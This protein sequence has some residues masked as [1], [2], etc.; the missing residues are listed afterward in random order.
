MADW[1]PPS[2]PKG[3]VSRVPHLPGLDGLRAVAVVAV[4]VYHANNTWL[5]GGFLGVEVFFVISGY[6]ITLLLIAEHERSGRVD[7]KQFWLRR[8]RRLLPALFGML[9]LLVVYLAV[10]FRSAQGRTRGDIVA[11]VGYISNWYQIWVGAGY[12]ASEAFAPLRHLWSLA[13]EEQFY[14]LWPIIM[15][16]I[17]SRGRAQLP[18]VALW[19]FGV[20]VA[21]AA[22]T[23]VLYVPGDISSACT[24]EAMHGYWKIAGRCVSVNDALYLGTI[25]RAGGLMMGAAFAMV[26]RPMALMRGPM[27]NKSR[28]LDVLALFG[29]A[30]LGYLFWKLHLAD[31][32][33]DINGSRFDPWL[34]RGGIFATGAATLLVIAAATHQRSLAG[35]LLGNPLF[36]W[37][38]TR[39]YGLYLYHWPIYQIIRKEAGVTLSVTQF[40][41]AML[42]TVPLTEL[43][44]RY[45]EMPIR[46]GAIGNWLRRER[47]RPSRAVAA[48]RRQL[49]AGGLAFTVLLGWAGVSIAM[50][51]NRCVG[52]V[53]CSLVEGQESSADD[54]IPTQPSSTTESTETATT[55][56][57]DEGTQPTGEPGESTTTA[58]T[59]A[60]TT[61]EPPPPPKP[62]AIGESVMLGAQPQLEAGGFTVIAVK[63]AQGADIANTIGQLR[64]GGQIG[65]TIVIQSGTNGSVS[66][67]TYAQ[68]MSFLPPDSTPKVIFLTVRAPGKGWIDGNNENIYA[69]PGQYPNVTVLE[70]KS[71]VDNG[72]VPGMAGDGIHLGTNAAKQT[73]ANMIFDVIGR[74]DLQVPVE[75]DG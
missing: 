40:V 74:R 50:A 72:L 30:A 14:L 69:L 71:F 70:W 6:L 64:A 75:A 39:S 43:S 1:S 61:T 9:A 57:N 25:T 52:E 58:T 59:A 24:P 35:V 37:I 22:V 29:V 16:A 49:A 63:S 42:V 4:M 62:L 26:W 5:H 47:R 60:P 17:L 54:T 11:G 3:Q 23:A 32:A 48:R 15:V 44:Y 20:S 18:R 45:V 33:L 13:V 31:P 68:M 8:A 66:A 27:R 2:T 53:E 19:L 34:F 56:A 67:E 10:G 21:I 36:D 7:L 51:P 55:V 73:Y 28:Q 46:R 38:G 41:A 12:T 65:D